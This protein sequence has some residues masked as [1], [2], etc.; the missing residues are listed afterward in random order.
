M[1]NLD[2]IHM[3]CDCSSLGGSDHQIVL[4]YFNY[5]EIGTFFLSL[6]TAKSIE[7]F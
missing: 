4:D 2:G 1:K 5:L 3:L 6:Q 7:L